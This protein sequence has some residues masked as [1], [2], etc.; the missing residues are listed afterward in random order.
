MALYVLERVSL[1]CP[2]VVPVKDVVA[3]LSAFGCRPGMFG[4]GVE[5]VKLYT[6][7]PWVLVKW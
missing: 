2:Q 7:D 1:F 3:V 6:K 5:S 4:K